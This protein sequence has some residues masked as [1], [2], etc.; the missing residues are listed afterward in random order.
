MV[1]QVVDKDGQEIQVGNLILY[2]TEGSIKFK[3][4]TV[5]SKI[6]PSGQPFI[7]GYWHKDKDVAIS[8]AG[9]K[10]FP[11]KDG[12]GAGWGFNFAGADYACRITLI[13]SNSSSNKPAN[14]T[15]QCQC[16][17]WT[18]CTCGA[19]VPWKERQR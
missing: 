4:Y 14:N 2:E 1:K 10:T 19:I 17:L 11:A 13:E 12:K 18:G 9:S 16:D 6:D 15:A 8:K 7:W 3:Q 5:I